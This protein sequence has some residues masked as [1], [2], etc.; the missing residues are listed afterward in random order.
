MFH[1]KIKSSE[2]AQALK[3]RCEPARAFGGTVWQPPRPFIQEPPRSS[4]PL[5]RYCQKTLRSHLHL[6]QVQ[7]W[8]L[9]VRKIYRLYRER[10]CFKLFQKKSNHSVGDSVAN[11]L[12]RLHP[13]RFQPRRRF[14]PGS[15]Y[16][17]FR[18][19]FR[20]KGICTDRIFP[21]SF[22]TVFNFSSNG[23]TGSSPS[24][25]E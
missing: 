19:T 8:R 11:S 22:Q 15:P 1:K 20:N 13:K 6:R 24:S 23:L 17:G 16:A 18:R 5:Q 25:A 12:L 7:V 21:G 3:C 4:P 14:I 10:N 9:G 2:E